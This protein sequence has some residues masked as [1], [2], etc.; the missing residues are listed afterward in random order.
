MSIMVAAVTPCSLS[1]WM[2]LSESKILSKQTDVRNPVW[3]PPVHELS[4]TGQAKGDL[5]GGG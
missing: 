4:G 3:Q 5:S 1:R 2:R